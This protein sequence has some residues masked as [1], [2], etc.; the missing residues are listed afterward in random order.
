MVTQRIL[1]PG[2]TLKAAL[3][4]SIKDRRGDIR[5][6]LH[7]P[8]RY[9]VKAMEQGVPYQTLIASVLHKQVTGRLSKQSQPPA[10]DATYG[11]K[12]PV[13]PS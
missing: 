11:K 10:R 7:R 8:R 5:L 12:P 3:A 1:A 13:M 2:V 9:P 4:T 6:V